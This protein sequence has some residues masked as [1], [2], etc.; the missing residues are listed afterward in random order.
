MLTGRTMWLAVLLIAL[1][2]GVLTGAMIILSTS[3]H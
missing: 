2:V 1:V 3:P